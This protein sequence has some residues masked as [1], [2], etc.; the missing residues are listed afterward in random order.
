MP[1]SA[2]ACAGGR[3][4]VHPEDKRGEGED[5]M[6]LDFSEEQNALGEELRRLL[7]ARSG[8]GGARDA[9]EGRAMFDAALWRELGQLGWLSV[10]MPTA[11]GGQ[12]LGAEML[13]RV[14]EE[15]GRSMAALPFLSSIGIVADAIGRLGTDEQKQRLLGGLATGDRIGA[16]AIAER[17]GPL[18]AEAIAARVAGSA[19]TGTKIAVS[20]GMVADLLLVVAVDQ[21]GPGLFLVDASATGRTPSAGVDPAHGP[22]TIRFDAAPA[23]RLG[24]GGWDGIADLL[25]RAA[26]PVAF[27]QIGAADA[28]LAMA[29]AYAT[30]RRAFGRQIGAFQAIKHK[31]ADVWI[32]NE[33]ARANAYHAAWA[34]GRDDAVLPL[35]AATARVSA[36]E[37]LERA[38]R[39]LIQVHG[40]IAVTWDHDAHLFYRRGQHLG[41]MLGGLREWQ[42][43]LTGRLAATI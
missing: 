32:A 26:V 10:A 2:G 18:R 30:D 15:I 31:L 24:S 25:D 7:A 8:L 41:L 29:T 34:L 39:E 23:E 38:A 3:R 40:G 12:D 37:A 13:C 16:F 33:L 42:H 14:A 6:N 36:T 19:L 27:A 4:C 11:S 43:R 1:A 28:A 17:A 21:D 20:D 5:G 35:A 22:A 9:L